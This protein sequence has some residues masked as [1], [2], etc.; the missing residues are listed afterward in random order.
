MSLPVTADRPV[1]VGVVHLLPL[2]GAPVEGPGLEAVL[3][4]AQG[5]VRVL[6]E[7]GCDAV[8]V[9]NLG[10]APFGS[11]EVGPFT[12][13]A[14]TRLVGAVM[15]AAPELS[16]GVNVLRNDALAAMA[17]AAATGAGFVR[18]NVHTGAMVTD[19][20]L[21]EGRARETLLL[22]RRLGADVAIVADV[23]VKHAVPLGPW[24]LPDAAR[25]AAARGRADVLV[26][27]GAG[28]GRPT[29]P[30]DVAQVREVVEVPVWVGSG[31][32]PDT[33]GAFGPLAGAI[34]G[35]ALHVDGDVTA[36]VE[37]ARVRAMRDA[38]AAHPSD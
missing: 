4:R 24:T 21:I 17:V 28:T 38:L 18:V 25:D 37:L 12:V 9:E 35:T 13:A 6:A 20:G 16:I 8:I 22:R 11:G 31:L 3:D 1:F 10:D 14:M 33:L 27:T 36:P 19:Q 29:A 23:L 15:R 30:T 26:V 34:V 32:G 5:D 2:P 7:G